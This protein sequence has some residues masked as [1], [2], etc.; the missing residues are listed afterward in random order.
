MQKFHVHLFAN[1]ELI[2]YVY[3]N[4]RY[5]FQN[6]QELSDCLAKCPHIRNEMDK[7]YIVYRWITQYIAYDTEF[8]RTKGVTKA[9]T[10]AQSVLT[11]GISVCQG[12]AELFNDLLKRMNIECVLVGGYAKLDDHTYAHKLE[13]H[14][15]NAFRLSNDVIWR[16]VDCTWGAG[17]VHNFIFIKKSTMF[18]FATPPSVFNKTHFSS[19]FYLGKTYAHLAEFVQGVKEDYEMVPCQMCFVFFYVHMLL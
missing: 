16:Y 15:W 11:N 17:A 6:I 13:T 8:L 3:A 1:K 2:N 5:Q 7:V 14:A 18:Y 4:P 19:E 12:Y 10:D 9:P